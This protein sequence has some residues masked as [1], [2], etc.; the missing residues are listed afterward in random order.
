MI[1]QPLTLKYENKNALKVLL[2]HRVW[3]I[4]PFF[5]NSWSEK[6]IL[7]YTICVTFDLF[8]WTSL[9]CVHTWERGDINIQKNPTTIICND[10]QTWEHP[11]MI[12][13]HWFKI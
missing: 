1:D 5:D 4:L 7:Y 9:L 12:S 3:I 8:D 13:N 6:I 11:L 10:L 2:G